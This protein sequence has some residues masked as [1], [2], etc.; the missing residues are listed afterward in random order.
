MKAACAWLSHDRLPAVA[1]SF[2]K[3]VIWFRQGARGSK[4]IIVLNASLDTVETLSLSVFTGD[5]HFRHVSAIGE[6]RELSGTQLASPPGHVRMV[7][8]DLAPWS[9]HLLLN[10]PA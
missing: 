4:A 6:S 9:I 8:S 5:T 10:G 1:A 3:V 7:L 2:A